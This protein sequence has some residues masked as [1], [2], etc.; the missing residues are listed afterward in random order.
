MPLPPLCELVPPALK[1]SLKDL[2]EPTYRADQI[3]RG[4]FLR[5]QRRYEGMTDLPA[6]L[7]ARLATELPLMTSRVASSTASADGTTKLLVALADG[8]SVECVLIPDGDRRTA[9]LS[10]Q[11]G[12]PIGCV[13]CASGLDGV[14]RNLTAGEI[15]E[16]AVHLTDLL[17]AEERLTNLVI[18]GM[19]EPFLN[20]DHL[21]HALETLHA[22][23]GLGIGTNRITV[24]TVGHVARIASFAEH[25][26][27]TN[28]AV[29]LH[30]PD[31]ALR[32]TLI[33]HAPPA[34]VAEIVTAAVNYRNATGKDVTFEYV[35]IADRNDHAGHAR[36][37]ARL[38][39]RTGIK[40][41]LIPLNP[42]RD[43]ALKAPLASQVKVFQ[44][45][46]E[47]EG[48]TCT[49]RR[50]RGSEIAAACGQLRL[51]HVRAAGASAAAP[52]A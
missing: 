27:A 31:D 6:A 3:L 28:L 18:M 50:R 17:P 22:K 7:R 51:A 13:F 30:A 16:Q 1:K 26:L 4:F 47:A 49:V 35:L 21:L 44:L 29:S 23:W 10:T 37:L 48:V 19:G 25:P 33:P 20:Y 52:Q 2:G 43:V 8:E 32:Q 46:V 5:R 39:Q 41:N 14:K 11:V 38:I 24:S 42:I 12:C 40:V 45:A 34:T 36:A 9:C 15:V